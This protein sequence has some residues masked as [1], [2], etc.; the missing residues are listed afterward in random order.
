MAIMKQIDEC[1]TRF[2]QKKMPLRKKWRAHLNCARFNP[3]LLLFH[4]DH[5]IL[6]FDLT[7]EKILNQWWER[8]ADK[9]GLDSAV[10]WLD[11]NN[12]KVKV[13]VSLIGR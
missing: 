12:E 13:F 1:L 7:E 5:L 8:A 6:E 4:Y 3:T 10:E 11:K 2:V 9:R